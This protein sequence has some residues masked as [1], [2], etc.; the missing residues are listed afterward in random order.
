M[1][2]LEM[3]MEIVLGVLRESYFLFG[4]MAPFLVF[5]YLLSGMLH[6]FTRPG[7]IS[8]HLGEDS[9]AS[10]VKASLFGAPLPLCSC[11]VIPASLALKKDGASRGAV[12]SFLISTPTTGVDSILATYALLGPFFTV[13]RV[14]ASLITGIFSGTI[15][16][17]LL[18]KDGH[19]DGVSGGCPECAGREVRAGGTVSIKIKGILRYAYVDLIKDTG[20]ALVAGILLG[21][22]IS[23]LMPQ[24]I[25]ESYLGYGFLPMLVMLVVALPMYVCATA[26]IPIAAALMLKGL[27]PGAAFVFLVAGPATNIVTMSVVA[28]NMGKK[29]LAVYLSSIIFCSFL[30]GALL[31]FLWPAFSAELTIAHVHDAAFSMRGAAGAASVFLAAMISLDLLKRMVVLL[32]SGKGQFF[33][34]S[35]GGK[36]A[37]DIDKGES[38]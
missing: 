35:V 5:G 37:H 34:K 10:V 31:N 24:H 9:L 20:P 36:K 14:M 26:S 28:R 7:A 17:V 32:R 27:A 33:E 4:R 22:V 8:S 3:V 29:T 38:A 11:A 2:L 6:V 16:N 13:Y 19:V 15:A 12:L 18:K 25:V 23:F 21:G 30:M 1:T